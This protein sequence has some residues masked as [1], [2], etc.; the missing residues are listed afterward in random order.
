MKGRLRSERVKILFHHRGTEGTEDH[1]V[2]ES[3]GKHRIEKNFVI[4]IIAHNLSFLF[5][6]EPLCSLCL[7]GEKG[8]SPFRFVT[9][10]LA[11]RLPDLSSGDAFF[12]Q[13]SMPML[14]LAPKVKKERKPGGSL[15]EPGEYNCGDPWSVNPR[16]RQ[17]GLTTCPTPEPRKIPRTRP[18]NL[19]IT[20]RDQYGATRYDIANCPLDFPRLHG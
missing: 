11:V 2:L 15:P 7:C 12:Y 17:G 3:W 8:F 20:N 1:R 5:L 14:D 9:S 4:R 19:T 18:A 10:I 13:C 6:C 16:A